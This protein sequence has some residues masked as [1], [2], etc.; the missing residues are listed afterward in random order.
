MDY[1]LR[2]GDY[3]LV[4]N[5]P[6]VY[7]VNGISEQ[8]Q[9]VSTL[10]NS[11]LVTVRV[12]IPH[13]LATGDP[14]E[15]QG[16]T[17]KTANGK[18]LVTNVQDDNTFSY[19]TSQIQASTGNV[20]TAYTTILPGT[21]AASDIEYDPNESIA[22][23]AATPSTLTFTTNYTHGISTSTSLYITNTVGKKSFGISSTTDIA[24]GAGIVTTTTPIIS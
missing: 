24:D 1:S 22:N 5:I 6:S 23:D 11:Y 13:G 9:T 19:K 7:T 3:E 2:S 21:F 4:N 20:N 17:S 12:G 10:A 15:V 14:I 18:Y 8:I 16:L